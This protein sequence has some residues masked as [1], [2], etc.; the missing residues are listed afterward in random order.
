MWNIR[1][2]AGKALQKDIEEVLKIDKA[3]IPLV[4]GHLCSGVIH[5]PGS[6]R[7]SEILTNNSTLKI[8]AL[9]E[10]YKF[11]HNEAFG[12]HIKKFGRAGTLLD[13]LASN[14]YKNA[15]S[16]SETSSFKRFWVEFF[17]QE[18][19]NHLEK[20]GNGGEVTITI[21]DVLAKA[22]ELPFHDDYM[23]YLYS[24]GEKKFSEWEEK[25][26]EGQIWG[27]RRVS[28]DLVVGNQQQADL[29]IQLAR[30]YTSGASSKSKIENL[31]ASEEKI[32]I[33]LFLGALQTGFMYVF[34]SENNGNLPVGFVS[35]NMIYQ[36]PAFEQH[37]PI[38][39]IS[40]V[41]NNKENLPEIRN[42]I[43]KIL[44]E[45]EL[46]KVAK[47][48]NANR[49]TSTK[50]DIIRLV[51]TS[52]VLLP[53]DETV[54]ISKIASAFKSSVFP[55]WVTAAA[56]F[57]LSIISQL[58]GS[59]H[60]GMPLNFCLG[61]ADISELKD[62]PLFEM[63]PLS[64]CRINNPWDESG[65]VDLTNVEKTVK[66]IA[67]R[68]S[69]NNYSWFQD[70]R[71]ALFWDATLPKAAPSFLVRLTE[72]SWNVF[73]NNSCFKRISKTNEHALMI[74]HLGGNG[75]GG[76]ILNGESLFSFRRK[77]LHGKVISEKEVNMAKY[78]L[79]AFQL[80]SVSEELKKSAAKKFS[81]IILAVSED[82]H[83]GA[84]IIVLSPKKQYSSDK[85]DSFPFKTEMGDPWKNS[86]IEDFMTAPTS[87]LISLMA[88]DGG[89][90]IY[91]TPD[92]KIKLSFRRLVTP[93]SRTIKK[94]SKKTHTD[95]DG[96][97]SRKWSAALAACHPEANL[98]VAVSQ[99]GPIIIFKEK[100]KNTI[101]TEIFS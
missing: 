44:E 75:S 67:K 55:H 35:G 97:G 72:G 43:Y 32:R 96:E 57:L 62:S 39:L 3:N 41:I 65:N 50:P 90:C 5:H 38:G 49:D 51:S 18:N 78:F 53:A 94:L 12:K 9:K 93:P 82:P 27:A 6:L 74:A 21:S 64:E 91:Q 37:G 46:A 28:Y 69:K 79:T 89:T 29:I 73:I 58:R 40:A 99:D 92:G 100:D 101:E 23:D 84:M 10:Q 54:V 16:F 83:M 47:K 85:D 20:S 87:D 86:V 36:S 14:A 80:S 70:G 48:I 4:F 61:F 26:L 19:A 45:G 77:D 2:E 56:Q 66:E 88:M 68:I 17:Q 98:V 31:T 22:M 81:E 34:A 25:F 33:W 76:I 8:E 24:S 7:I 13:W 63:V 95:L 60:E 59:I 71:Y 52:S 42:S 30:L 15:V 1:E 11:P